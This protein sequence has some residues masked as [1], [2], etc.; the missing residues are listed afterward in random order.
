MTRKYWIEL[1]QRN[2]ICTNCNTE[3]HSPN[4]QWCRTCI[5][6]RAKIR[7]K[8]NGGKWYKLLTPEQK[9]KRRARAAIYTDTSRGYIKRQPCEVC[10]D[11]KT[12]AH[13]Y[14]G[15]DWENAKKVRHLCFKHHREEEARIKKEFDTQNLQ[16]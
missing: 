9:K 6:A 12:Q 10:G 8:L 13:H 5:N 7:R 1:L 15:Y 16:A 14:L 3:P 4:S 11:P 2:P